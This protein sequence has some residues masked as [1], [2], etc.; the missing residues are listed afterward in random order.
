MQRNGS[1]IRFWTQ[2]R[3]EAFKRNTTKQ[4]KNFECRRNQVV[5]LPTS[6]FFFPQLSIS[7]YLVDLKW[8]FLF[9]QVLRY[10][11]G[12]KTQTFKEPHSYLTNFEACLLLMT[13]VNTTYILIHRRCMSSCPLR[14]TSRVRRYL[15]S[16][17]YGVRIYLSGRSHGPP[18][19][20]IKNGIMC[21]FPAFADLAADEAESYMGESCGLRVP[22]S[23]I[24][25]NLN[26]KSSPR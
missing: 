4:P 2:T 14:E 15:E 22:M 24:S 18:L 17:G 9:L 10:T 26:M 16:E 7:M 21:H 6:R 19:D 1:G 23:P 20:Q 11:S 13:F 8:S 5:V 12:G 3:I 25:T